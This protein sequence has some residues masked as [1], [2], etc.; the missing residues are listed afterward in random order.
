MRDLRGENISNIEK[1]FVGRGGAIIK[2]VASVDVG[3]I[4]ILIIAMASVNINFC[5]DE[6]PFI[7]LLILT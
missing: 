1:N 7:K 5:L 2:G 4:V 6:G 3:I